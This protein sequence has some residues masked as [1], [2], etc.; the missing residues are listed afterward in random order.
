MTR[1]IDLNADL[2]E[3][4]GDDAAMLELVTSANVA[5]GGHAGDV[6]SMTATVRLAVA[7]G[8]CIGAHPGYEDKVDFGRRIIPMEPAEISRMV[9]GQIGALV[10]VAAA[11]GAAVRYVKVHGALAN[12][13]ARDRDVANAVTEAIG[14]VD[15]TL[16]VLAISGTEI[17]RVAR[18]AGLQAVSEIFADRG[19]TPDGQLVPRDEPGAIIHD[20]HEAAGRL[21]GFLETGAMPSVAGDAVPLDAQ[22]ICV[23]GDTPGAVAMAQIIRDRLTGA[24]V[25]VE[26]FLS[27]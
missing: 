11:E 14:A 23:H 3:G 10:E 9:A 24:G 4:M 1:R 8:V 22:S 18:D 25:R 2:G 6:E 20:A 12:L 17:E 19:Y 5:C 26:P 16:A 15:A 13:A 27:P 7:N 21:L